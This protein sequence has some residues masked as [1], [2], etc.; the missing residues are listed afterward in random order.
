MP[1]I[2]LARQ[3]AGDDEPKPG[4]FACM[5]FLPLAAFGPQ[6]ARWNVATRMQETAA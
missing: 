1:A 4:A 2:L 6:F 3:L 5:G